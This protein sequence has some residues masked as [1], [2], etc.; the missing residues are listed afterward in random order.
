MIESNRR[1]SEGASLVLASRAME[2]TVRWR[3]FAGGRGRDVGVASIIQKSLIK[4]QK[5][6][7]FVLDEKAGDPSWLVQVERWV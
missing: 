6:R 4:L 1:L 3:L 7:A 5:K 2:E